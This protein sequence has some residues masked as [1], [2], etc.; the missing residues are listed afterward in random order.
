MR[1]KQRPWLNLVL[2]RSEEYKNPPPPPLINYHLTCSSLLKRD[3]QKTE[4][5]HPRTLFIRMTKLLWAHHQTRLWFLSLTCVVVLVHRK[6]NP[7]LATGTMCDCHWNESNASLKSTCF[8]FPPLLHNLPPR[9]VTN[10][11]IVLSQ[12]RVATFLRK[13]PQ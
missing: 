12:L 2:D 5:N 10:K 4:P 1:H 6:I 11:E 8:D 3:Q 7:S 13:Y 9:N